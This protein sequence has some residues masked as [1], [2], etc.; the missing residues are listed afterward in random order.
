MK[1]HVWL[2]GWAALFATVGVNAQGKL[3]VT[4]TCKGETVHALEVGDRPEHVLAVW[5][6]ACTYVQ[7]AEIGGE[8]LIDGYSVGFSED[9]ATDSATSGHH[10]ATAEDGARFFL[11]FHGTT[12]LKHLK[13]AGPTNGTWF[14]SGGT[15]RLEGIKGKGTYKVTRNDDGTFTVVVEGRYEL[16][17]S[18]AK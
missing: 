3:S 5:K 18:K 16:S 13:R 10:V 15:G 7:P 9:T 12:P 8:K 17:G 14:Y 1:R 11:V 4:L 6:E 2:I